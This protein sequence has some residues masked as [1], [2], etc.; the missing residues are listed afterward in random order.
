MMT[1]IAAP[2]FP[3]YEAA[4]SSRK[5]D[6]LTDLRGYVERF[7][8]REPADCGQHAITRPLEDAASEPLRKSVACAAAA[9]KVRRP[10]W[11]YKQGQGVDSLIF[12]GLLG[13]AE[14]TIYQFEY[15]SAPCGGP[16]CAGRF[17][18]QRCDR[19]TVSGIPGQPV[20]MFGCE[21]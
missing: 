20:D 3:A 15:D 5:S 9:A 2:S 21:R 11:T 17:V 1:M 10:F 18:I 13:T 7:T 16:G 14:G 8:G 4:Q 12:S 6:A 19:P